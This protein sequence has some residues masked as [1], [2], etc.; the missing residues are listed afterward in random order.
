VEESVDLL[1][2]PGDAIV[3]PPIGP[4]TPSS[5]VRGE[6]LYLELGCANCH[7]EDGAG[8]A[9]EVWHD[10]RGFPVR[11]RDLARE[12]FKG[13]QDATSVYLRI[14]A[15]MPGGP[16]PS[17]SGVSQQRLADLVQFCLSL[18][19]EP[20]KALTDHERA[21][22]ATCRAYLASLGVE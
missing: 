6:E 3:V 8:V 19:R 20:K 18:S 17:S 10:E 2:S 7:G 22:L 11:A 9:G 13:G 16:H 12:S 5:L 4:A 15:G 14:A 1:T 21:A